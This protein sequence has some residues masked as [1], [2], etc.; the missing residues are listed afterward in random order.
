MQP[1]STRS[2]AEV[3]ARLARSGLSCAGAGLRADGSVELRVQHEQRVER[4]GDAVRAGWPGA[5]ASVH[6]E[7]RS[8][9][10]HHAVEV[11]PGLWLTW[12]VPLPR[13]SAA[14]LAP[15]P[16]QG[17]RLAA[18]HV[19]VSDQ[20]SDAEVVLASS[21]DEAAACYAEGWGL[22]PG[23]VLAVSE[24]PLGDEDTLDGPPP[25]VFVVEARGGVSAWQG[26]GARRH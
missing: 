21:P 19:G 24:E 18:Y 3:L 26:W 2:L 9:A 4:T 13:P 17:D 10:T 23:T 16:A 5:V 12:Q 6:R 25:R 7:R 15:P 8:D 20:E 1:V 14:T 11:Q 22:R